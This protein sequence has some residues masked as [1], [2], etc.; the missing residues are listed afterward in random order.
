MTNAPDLLAALQ[1]AI[2]DAKQVQAEREAREA[3]RPKVRPRQ[4]MPDLT[5]GDLALS[6]S[7]RLQFCHVC[8]GGIHLGSPAAAHYP[9]GRRV[10]T[11]I[12]YYH[13]TCLPEGTLP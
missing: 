11:A 5:A 6:N 9:A 3:A 1:R 12:T 10:S 2:E 13:P 8:G 7:A 4:P